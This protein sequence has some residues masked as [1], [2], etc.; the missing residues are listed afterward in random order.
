MIFEVQSVIVD[1]KKLP[2][3]FKLKLQIM[4]LN[5][6]YIFGINKNVIFLSQDHTL[7]ASSLTKEALISQYIKKKRSTI[8]NFNVI[9][10]RRKD[11]YLVCVKS[12]NNL[13]KKKVA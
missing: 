8:F 4:S 3:L 10:L 12:L 13:K 6:R 9:R 1:Y 7:S 5:L 11:F 2:L